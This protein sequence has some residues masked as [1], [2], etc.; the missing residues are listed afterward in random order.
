MRKHSKNVLESVICPFA[1]SM[2]K[3]DWNDIKRVISTDDHKSSVIVESNSN[4]IFLVNVPVLL[5]EAIFK[6]GEENVIEQDLGF[7][8]LS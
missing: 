2:D 8:E 4:E 7:N 3:V 5:Y 1:L 6:S